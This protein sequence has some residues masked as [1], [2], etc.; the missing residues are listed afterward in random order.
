MAID[1]SLK[2][3]PPEELYRVIPHEADSNGRKNHSIR[4]SEGTDC[5]AFCE[6]LNS[7]G[8]ECI[9]NPS[10]FHR[11]CVF[12]FTEE[13]ANTISERD[14]V[15]S[16][17]VEQDK[18]LYGYN[19]QNRNGKTT[20]E[21]YFD[22]SYPSSTFDGTDFIPAKFFWDTNTTA[23]TPNGRP[24]GFFNNAQFG[25][26]TQEDTYASTNTTISHNFDGS[27]VDIVIVDPSGGA[28]EQPSW[29]QAHPDF[30]DA[31][32]NFRF[33][34]VDWGDYDAGVTNVR[35][36]QVTNGWTDFGTHALGCASVAAG[37]YCG[38]AKNAN[39]YYADA[40]YDNELSIY[41]AILAWHQAKPV[42]PDTG[43][44][45]A[46]IVNNSWGYAD[47]VRAENIIPIEEIS[48]FNAFDDDGNQTTVTRPGGGWGSDYSD[49]IDNGF[50][51]VNTTGANGTDKWG[52]ATFRS[53]SSRDT[54]W[55]AVLN[56]FNDV[57]GIYMFFAS[58]NSPVVFARTDQPQYNNQIFMDSN[59]FYYDL[60]ESTGSNKVTATENTYAP[61]TGT[62]YTHRCEYLGNRY[63]FYV[64]SYQF[65]TTNPLMEHYPAR[66]P[67]IDA[68]GQGRGSWCATSVYN[69][70]TDSNGFEWGTFSGTSAACPNVVGAV[71]LML[72][73]Y[74]HGEGGASWPS[75]AELRTMIRSTFS[76]HP[77]PLVEDLG[78]D[79]SGNAVSKTSF[80]AAGT[81]M[82]GHR[83]QGS[84]LV[85]QTMTQRTQL[86]ERV[87]DRNSYN[88]NWAVSVGANGTTAYTFTG[89]VGAETFSSTNDPILVIRKGDT[90]TFSINATGHPMYIKQYKGSVVQGSADAYN[91]GVTN[92][93]TQSG[94]M[95]WAT[96]TVPAGL[97]Y[98][99]C[100][101]HAAMAN[102]IVILSET[103]Y[104]YSGS[105]IM[106]TTPNTRVWLPWSIRMGTAGKTKQPRSI[107]YTS[108]PATG[109]TYPRRKI[110]VA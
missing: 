61:V 84:Y 38:W 102:Y 83:L 53:N 36:N 81:E 92:N 79:R 42:N 39:L 4:L 60:N 85:N 16:V 89:T 101:N 22:T 43:K 29:A 41:A 108:R 49:F 71:A 23:P 75:I 72:D 98:Y 67:A 57:N 13:E 86:T 44:R 12:K 55:D 99:I 9:A 78:K 34:A 66:G 52:I 24:L 90:L 59:Y 20:V 103:E 56:F 104:Y 2:F 58:G 28:L 74:Y 68:I 5:D 6:D 54:V 64:S 37:T 80:P 107:T 1:E 109:Q 46:T 87:Q 51:V 30:K 69:V 105:G 17:N 96:D 50:N 8:F 15:V 100:S 25:G 26:G 18:V 63:S 7:Q 82:W 19:P 94:F 33:V 73:H 62:E 45:N 3:L 10:M 48:S 95:I 31:S 11:I 76:Q 47:D 70:K 40:T 91:T 32:N 35:N 88:D 65:S 106:G 93:G 77:L 27:T 14:D 21:T 110:R 97:Y